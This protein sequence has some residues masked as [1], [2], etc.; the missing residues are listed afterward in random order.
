MKRNEGVIISHIL[1]AILLVF[2]FVNVQCRDPYEF[3]PIFDSLTPPPGAPVLLHP[4]NDTIYVEYSY[5][6]E[7]V[8][9]WSYIDGAEYYFFE[10]STTSTFVN[11]EKMQ[12]VSPC[13]TIQVYPPLPWEKVFYYWR[14][15]AYCRSWWWY[16]DWSETWHFFFARK[17]S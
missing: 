1:I 14:V 8:F 11:P 5:P 7:I 16:T 15:R 17:S 6:H 2:Y 9:E 4:C 13:C 12:A 3:E 10:L